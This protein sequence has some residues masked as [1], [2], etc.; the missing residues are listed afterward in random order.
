MVIH[1]TRLITP[2]QPH[3]AKTLMVTLESRAHHDESLVCPRK[4]V[5]DLQCFI[6]IIIAARMN[7]GQ[8][9][10]EYHSNA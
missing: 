1:W 6:V 7:A 8:A 10:Y 4:N 3:W 5:I 2:L 9:A